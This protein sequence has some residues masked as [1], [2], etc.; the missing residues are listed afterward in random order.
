MVFIKTDAFLKYKKMTVFSYQ[1]DSDIPMYDG[2]LHTQNKYFLETTV[3]EVPRVIQ[4]TIKHQKIV[5][6]AVEE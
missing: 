4:M 2:Q 1:G 3:L 5:I 6:G